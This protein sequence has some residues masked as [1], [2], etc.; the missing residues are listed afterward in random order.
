MRFLAVRWGLLVTLALPCCA[1]D[2]WADEPAKPSRAVFWD[3]FRGPN[4]TG[5]SDDKNV[6]LTFGANENLLW[7]VALPGAGN[8][9]PIVWGDLP[10]SRDRQ[11][12]PGSFLRMA[13]VQT[14]EGALRVPP[15]HHALRAAAVHLVP[16]H[17]PGGRLW[18][19]LWH[20]HGS[21]D[22]LRRRRLRRAV[23]LSR[24]PCAGGRRRSIS[25]GPSC[26]CRPTGR[27]SSPARC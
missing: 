25:P 13:A 5:T 18:R 21:H 8:S 26:S 20:T 6:P 4:G 9:S 22:A 23:P 16:R 24:F 27:A 15:C 1:P 12:S 19:R 7:K 2:V 14:V 17:V 3:R 11:E 10:E